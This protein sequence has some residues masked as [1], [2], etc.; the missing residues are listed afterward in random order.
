MTTRPESISIRDALAALGL[1]D[2]LPDG[3][4][5]PFVERKARLEAWK[6]D[7]LQPRFKQLAREL[8]PDR[9]GDTAAMAKVNAARD[10][11]EGMVPRADEAPNG[12]I[13]FV[14]RTWSTTTGGS[15]TSSSSSTWWRR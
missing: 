7:V 14:E 4:G 8:H 2:S 5:L 1:A 12:R 3:R 15:F 6:R 10:L 13:V 9:G 11:L